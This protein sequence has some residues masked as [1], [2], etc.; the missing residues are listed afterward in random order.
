LDIRKVDL[1]LLAVLDAMLEHQSVTRAGSMLGLS[2]P[3][4]SAA[5]AKL[6]AQFDDPLFVRTGRGM[7]ATPRALALAD[8]VHRVLDT[9]REE[10]LQKAAFD[11][12]SADC[13]FTI[14]TP[15]IGEVVLLPRLAQHLRAAAPCIRLRALPL[16]AAATTEALES[17]AA[18]LAVGYFPDLATAGFYQQRLFRN[19][20][21]CI[22]R[23]DHPRIGER[24]TLKQFLEASH[25]VV[26]PAGRSHL[27][28]Q[29]LEKR[30][31]RRHVPVDI[32]H[33]TS[34]LTIIAESDLIAT[35]PRDVGHVFARL[36]RIRLVEPPISPPPFDVKQHWHRRFHNDAANIW[37]RQAVHEAFHD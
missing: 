28:D 19:S 16:H 37:L 9:I 10:I 1:N 26:R 23:T 7:K 33:F 22:V 27:F 14:I 15:D 24:I 25:A 5:L 4:M 18:D 20:F 13:T 8:P 6:R 11:P 17:G 3:A 35:V 34:L 2:Q 32:G 36:A 29:Y 21:V 30:K 31:L 12:A